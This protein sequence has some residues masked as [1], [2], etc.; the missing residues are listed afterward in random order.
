MILRVLIFMIFICQNIYSQST[1]IGTVFDEYSLPMKDVL[2]REINFNLKTQTNEKGVFVLNNIPDKIRTLELEF[3]HIGYKIEVIKVHLDTGKIFAHEM[4]ADIFE[5]EQI[6]ITGSR[7]ETYLKD[8]PLK[9]EVLTEKELCKINSF[10]FTQALEYTP[11][12]KIQNNCGVCGTNDIRILGLEGQY[13][14]ILINGAPIISNLGTV[15][16]LQ[17]FNVEDIK[18]VEIIKGPGS[19]LYGPEAIAGT[20]NLILKDPIEKPDFSFDVSTSSLLENK[21]FAGGTKKWNKVKASLNAEIN[22]FNKRTDGNNDGFTDIPNYKRYILLNRWHIDPGFNTHIELTGRYLYEDRFGGQMNWDA[23]L[24]R[25]GNV[26]YGE[27][28]YTNRQEFIGKINKKISDKVRLESN[29]SQFYHN[30]N[31]FYGTTKYNAGQFSIY[32]DALLFHK[33]SDNNSFIFGGGYKHEDYDDNTP[34]TGDSILN[35]PASYRIFSLFMQSENTIFKNLRTSA[36]IRYNY[37]NIQKS[38]LQPRFSIKYNPLAYTTIRF[39]AGTGFR[40]V[41]IFSEDHGA[42]TGTRQIIIAEDLKPEKSINFS[43]GFIQDIDLGN[44][45]IRIMLDAYYTRFSNQIIPDY[46]SDPASIIYRNLNGYS[47]SQGFSAVFE[48]Q[49]SIPLK[50]KIS[51][52][53]LNS[54]RKNDNGKEEIIFFNPKHK[55]NADINYRINK[56]DM[57][58]SLLAK[59]VGVQRLPLFLKPYPR[60]TESNPYSIWN[61]QI[62][63]SINHFNIYAGIENIFNYRQDSPLIDPNNPFGDLFDTIYIYG[64]L[65]G[66]K[67]VFGFHFDID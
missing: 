20:I 38:I 25:G 19:I 65:E 26:V 18:Q 24:H 43:G 33:F 6:V 22:Y 21:F 34:A 1:F 28:I 53:Y 48:Y 59:Y 39:S 14:Q 45:F 51:Y 52:D 62:N 31:S 44:Q 9:I 46:N 54:F 47:V 56:Y 15:Y 5:T 8:S 55:I 67:F 35:N 3:S 27:S 13:T 11:G 16:G 50:F 32:G 61:F 64:P 29:F 42:L 2:V 60:A 40:T 7:T 58:I 30:Q 4:K 12:I 37:H 17:G 23:G 57:E 63:K 66:R 49:F 41:N 36:G 10:N